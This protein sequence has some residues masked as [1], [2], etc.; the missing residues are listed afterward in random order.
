[1]HWPCHPMGLQSVMADDCQ[2]I[3]VHISLLKRQATEAY[4]LLWLVKYP[5]R[6]GSGE[7][8][9]PTERVTDS[10]LTEDAITCLLPEPLHRMFKNHSRKRICCILC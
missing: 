9:A 1:M 3:V 2:V 10:V 6:L 4:Q 5:A 7:P 8:S